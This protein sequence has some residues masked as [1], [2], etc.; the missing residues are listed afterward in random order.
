V[1]FDSG[2]RDP[3]VPFTSAF[4][5]DPRH[6]FLH[7]VHASNTRGSSSSGKGNHGATG[8][9]NNGMTIA[10]GLGLGGVSIA[11]NDQLILQGEVDGGGATQ[12]TTSIAMMPT[13][14]TG[15]GNNSVVSPT[16]RQR[17]VSNSGSVGSMIM[18]MAGSFFGLDEESETNPRRA[19]QLLTEIGARLMRRRSS[20]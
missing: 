3:R 11:S 7:G 10:L 4:S 8:V 16:N 20:S 1:L 15:D 12:R 6:R 19:S 2:E 5:V 14:I 18:S 13:A 9:V 17:R